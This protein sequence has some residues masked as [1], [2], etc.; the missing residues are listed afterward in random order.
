M[1]YSTGHDLWNLIKEIDSWDTLFVT[2]DLD[3]TRINVESLKSN[4]RTLSR[5]C[6]I[7]LEL[8]VRFWGHWGLRWSFGIEEV[9]PHCRIILEKNISSTLNREII[10]CGFFRSVWVRKPSNRTRKFRTP[11]CLSLVWAVVGP[12][13]EEIQ[14]SMGWG[15]V[16]G[17]GVSVGRT[18]VCRPETPSL[19]T[20]TETYTVSTPRRTR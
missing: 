3:W 12:K 17:R 14:R 13:E 8:C 10:N 4:L 20:K 15:K 7:R 2:L 18:N 1:I 19:T 16:F 5:K 9:D 6:R 11:Y